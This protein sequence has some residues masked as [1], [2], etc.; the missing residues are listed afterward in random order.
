ML[1]FKIVMAG[2]TPIAV[3]MEGVSAE[4]QADVEIIRVDSQTSKVINF[5]LLK[6]VA[7]PKVL[8]SL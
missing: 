8:Q 2:D 3:Y 7:D 1:K 5:P 6:E 4:I